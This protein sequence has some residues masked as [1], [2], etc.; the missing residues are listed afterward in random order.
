MAMVQ[1]TWRSPETQKFCATLGLR[2]AKRGNRL[3]RSAHA[4][5]H[6]DTFF[7]PIDCLK[8]ARFV[9]EC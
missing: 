9:E 7:N 8:E 1:V 2:R 3:Q 5:S 4:G 6:G